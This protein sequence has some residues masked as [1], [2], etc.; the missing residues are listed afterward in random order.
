MNGK[1][2]A[3][4]AVAIILASSLCI[5]IAASRTDGDVATG[6]S[7]SPLGSLIIDADTSAN[8]K[9]FYVSVGGNVIINTG[10]MSAQITPSTGSGLSYS[11]GYVTGAV[12]GTSRITITVDQD[13]GSGYSSIDFYIQP[14]ASGSSGGNSGTGTSDSPLSSLDTDASTAVGK[15]FYVK[16]GGTVSVRAANYR[17]VTD[18]TNGYGLTVSGG[19]LSGTLS[20][21]GEIDVSVD[22]VQ[23]G[24][25]TEHFTIIAVA[26]GA[27][28]GATDSGK[29]L[30]MAEGSHFFSWADAFGQNYN[31]SENHFYVSSTPC[32]ATASG[33]SVTPN[34]SGIAVTVPV[35]GSY[36]LCVD[37]DSHADSGQQI[38]SALTV[39]SGSS[40]GS[41]ETGTQSSPLS[42]LSASFGDAKG[43]T[44]YVAV[45]GSVDLS[46]HIADWEAKTWTG[47]FGLTI[48]YTG[49]YEHVSGTISKA[50]TITITVAEGS[51]DNV[52]TITIIAV[53]SG[54]SDSYLYTVRY[55]D[56]GDR[57]AVQTGQ[58]N[59]PY[60][61]I[62]VL[63]R[64]PVRSAWTFFGWSFTSS[65]STD[66]YHETD[67]VYVTSNSPNDLYASW[68]RT[69]NFDAD[70]G[71]VAGGIT[72]AATL[73]GKS[74]TLPGATRSGYTFDG[75]YTPGTSG[76][77]VGGAG[78]S[79]NPDFDNRTLYAHWTQSQSGTTSYTVTFNANGGN[80]GVSS[81]TYSGTPLEL[82]E[83]SR[84]GYSFDG[85]Y[86]AGG[87]QASS[88][89]TPTGD[90][91]LYAHWTANQQ[92]GTTHRVD[93]VSNPVG[94]GEF[95]FGGGVGAMETAASLTVADGEIVEFDSIGRLNV[96]DARGNITQ[97]IIVNPVGSNQLVGWSVDWVGYIPDEFT[98][99]EDLTLIATFVDLNGRVGISAPVNISAE[100]GSHGN[101]F[102]VMVL[103]SDS[104]LTVSGPSGWNVSA[105]NGTITFDVPANA[106]ID[107][108]TITLTGT[109]ASYGNG[110]AIINVHVTEPAAQTPVDIGAP[111]GAITAERGSQVRVNINPV[112]SGAS[113][114][115]T[116]EPSGWTASVSGNQVVINVPANA[117]LGNST[118]KL[119]GTADGY[120]DGTANITVKVIEA[121][122]TNLGISVS[123]SVSAVIGSSGNSVMAEVTP[124]DSGATLS[125]AA[126]SGWTV[127]ATQTS[128]GHWE[129]SY[130]VPSGAS[131]GDHIINLTAAKT[132]YTTA[133]AD[134]SVHVAPELVF[135]NS[136]TAACSI[137]EARA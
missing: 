51:D 99:N 137:S 21:A 93:L 133:T 112:P 5:P 69:T 71:T 125:A 121:T 65:G 27:P 85:W 62:N 42:G 77:R 56:R 102:N 82:P 104:T 83:P 13:P 55:Y 124:T 111:S 35:A 30:T 23:G 72:S 136:P 40:G 54:G 135:T 4:M 28:S 59:Q 46:G 3:V 127:N 33:T 101:S 129:I 61:Y 10:G 74:L 12:S 126:P 131:E 119:K 103:P 80:M 75:W 94:G 89:Y 76:S 18:V 87:T 63:P 41:P 43:K 57:V 6:T 88:P 86:T 98:V 11:S 19:G 79:Y 15:T 50:G 120:A 29:S 91:T 22:Y 117:S 81:M 105:N 106:S 17:A 123:G 107:N 70:G 1:M 92:S 118:V 109:K 114:T 45:G 34:S 78:D 84:N 36:Y 134:V 115:V 53:G 8:G 100:R 116:S 20:K 31:G 39:T 14:V 90:I 73:E 49:D 66:G 7:D 52:R 64:D 128:A 113:I 96:K 67:P 9:T 37:L 26:T 68:G 47:G 132:G 108:Y 95:Y 16:A 60:G 58:G 2:A 25:S 44:Y 48:S 97:Y 110:Q 32:G 130:T 122:P 24:G 38:Y